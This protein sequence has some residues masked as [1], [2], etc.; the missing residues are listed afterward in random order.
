MFEIPAKLHKAFNEEYGI[1]LAYHKDDEMLYYD[2]ECK[3]AYEKTSLTAINHWKKELDPNQISKGKLL[4]GYNFGYEVYLN[5]NNYYDIKGNLLK[6]FEIKEKSVIQ[7]LVPGYKREIK[8]FK[9]RDGSVGTKTNILIGNIACIDLGDFNES[10]MV[11]YMYYQLQYSIDKYEAFKLKPPLLTSRYVGLARVLEHEF[12]GHVLLKLTDDLYPW[13]SLEGRTM[14]PN[15]VEGELCNVIRKEIGLPDRL[16]Y[17][18]GYKIN[19]KDDTA[20]NIKFGYLNGDNRTPN[21]DANYDNIEENSDYAF[22]G[23]PPKFPKTEGSAIIS[24]KNYY[25]LQNINYIVKIKFN[26]YNETF[27]FS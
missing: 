21:P 11:K 3:P 27:D 12:I 22:F 7:G 25:A 2:G 4:L 1:K 9:F 16:N 18:G 19:N 26:I 20:L 10:L 17:G 23:P 15:Y 24:E 5:G 8:N 13:N 14:G 6:D